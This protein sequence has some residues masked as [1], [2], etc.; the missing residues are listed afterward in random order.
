MPLDITLFR[1]NGGNPESIRESQRRRYASVEIVDEIIAK[2]DIWR[3]LTGT[4]DNLKKK[5]NQI[6]KEIATIKKTLAASA[7]DLD[8][9]KIASFNSDCEKLVNE[10]VQFDNEITATEEKQKQL[11]VEIDSMVNKVSESI[12]VLLVHSFI[13]LFCFLFPSCLAFLFLTVSRFACL[14]S[15]C[16]SIL[17]LNRLVILFLILFPFLKTKMQIIA[18][19]PL[20]DHHV[21]LLVY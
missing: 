2:D 20:G 15:V 16:L 3:N 11:K 12:F 17:I 10:K 4:I 8:E 7:K 21:I 5:R 9:A 6:Q 14:S 13:V 1:V 19:K 18:L